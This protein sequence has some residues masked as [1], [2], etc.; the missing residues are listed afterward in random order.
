MFAYSPKY[1]EGNIDI[2]DSS[3]PKLSIV[4]SRSILEQ[5][6]YV[7]ENL[8]DEIKNFNICIVS[9]GMYGVDIY[10][11]NLALQNDMKTVF[12]LPQGISSYKKSSLN[13]QLKFKENSNYLYISDY[14][15]NFS[16]RKYTFLE[17]NKIISIVSDVTLVAQAS[18]KSGSLSTAFSALRNCKK[19]IA[20]PIS[21][22]NPQ[23]QGTNYLIGRGSVIY[24]N[25]ETVLSN[26]GINP[27][28]LDRRILEILI[29]GPKTISELVNKLDSNLS[30]VQKSLLKLI[31]EGEVS[32]DG[33]KYRYD[34]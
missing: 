20:V 6:K 4:G 30:L 11:H 27:L 28:N 10:A 15:D 5:T 32:F 16:P 25:P 21:L 3:Q 26:L 19:V 8:F 13:K 24:L 17:R 12:V 14:P 18:I 1:Y 9:G 2:L 22:H 31:L 34:L 23:F 33:A 7:L 29:E